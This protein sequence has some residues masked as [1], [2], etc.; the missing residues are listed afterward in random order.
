MM[1]GQIHQVYL[2]IDCEKLS[3][4]KFHRCVSCYRKDT[5][6]RYLAKTAQEIA[7]VLRRIERVLATFERKARARCVAPIPLIKSATPAVRRQ[8]LILIRNELTSADF[9]LVL[10]QST[11]CLRRRLLYFPSRRRAHATGKNAS[12]RKG[13]DVI[14]EQTQTG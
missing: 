11:V 12:E 6:W 13:A 9:N 5:Q 8:R 2:N 1:C 4:A 7:S 3:S 10:S 14:S